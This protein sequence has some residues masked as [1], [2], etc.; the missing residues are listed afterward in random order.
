[1]SLAL[2]AVGPCS[3]FGKNLV[4]TLTI[5][6]NCPPGFNISE[7]ASSCV[8]E[9]WLAKYTNSC[10]ITNGL[11]RI[12]RHSNQQFWVGYDHQSNKLILHPHCPLDYCVS[13]I[14]WLF[15]STIQMNN[16]HTTGQASCVGIARMVI[17]YYWI[18]LTVGS[19][20][21]TI[22]LPCSFLLH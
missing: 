1:M 6:H 12:T 14:Q 21:T 18:P 22:I 20:P 9:Q 16:V 15:L 17:V 7:S 11:G 3:T 5:N 13:H 2:Y 8:C 10:N 19:A 4:L